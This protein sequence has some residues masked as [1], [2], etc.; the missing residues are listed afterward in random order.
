MLSSFLPEET[1]RLNRCRATQSYGPTLV[2]L[3]F[4]QQIVTETQ[5]DC[6]S[7]GLQGVQRLRFLMTHLRE[8]SDVSRGSVEKAS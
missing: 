4:Q 8:F 3:C 6:T 5:A 1:G 7:E 2:H